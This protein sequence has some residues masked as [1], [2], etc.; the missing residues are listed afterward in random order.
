MSSTVPPLKKGTV[1]E[2]FE[3]DG[4][5]GKGGFGI[6]YR[7]RD[8]TLERNVAIKEYLPAAIAQR[9]T[10]SDT[11]T[12]SREDDKTLE[13]YQEGLERFLE[14]A[15]TLAKFNASSVVRVVYFFTANNTAYMVMQYEE[16]KDLAEYLRERNSPLPEQQVRGLLLD[17]LGGLQEVHEAG[18]LH[19][20]IKPENIYIRNDGSPVLLDFGSA[21]Q[22]A[23][24]Q[25]TQEM[26]AMV[27]SGYAPYEQYN[28]RGRQGPWSDLYSLGSTFYYCLSGKHP[29][30]SLERFMALHNG[31]PDPMKPLQELCGDRYSHEILQMVSWML[32]T[33]IDTRP[34]KASDLFTILARND[35][36]A[37]IT[38]DTQIL[39]EP[40]LDTST[41]S[42]VDWDESTLT[43]AESD[44]ATHLGPMARVLVKKVAAS[45]ETVEDL[46]ERLASSIESDVERAEFLA[47]GS[48]GEFVTDRAQKGGAAGAWDQHVLDRVTQQLAEFVGP[49]ASIL[50]KK[51]ASKTDSIDALY[52][53]LSS[54]VDSDRDRAK[55][56]NTRQKS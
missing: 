24:E 36:A 16:G 34:Q 37:D 42:P 50:V 46:Y 23:S 48:T 12:T 31:E 22:H 55:F 4:V 47:K 41:Q 39:D 6:T 21:R 25:L 54:H 45:T 40:V 33:Q 52:Q 14:E 18:V 56:L 32:S 29:V 51:A 35:P 2:S 27:S 28:R 3:I 11:V 8:T 43:Q 1:L 53:L 49:M 9:D 17:L 5:L 10:D 7:A 26:T 19:R 20:D 13:S 30:D 15:R 38:R 44:L